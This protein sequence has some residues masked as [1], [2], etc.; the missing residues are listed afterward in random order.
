M[1]RPTRLNVEYIRKIDQPGCYGDGRGGF[2]LSLLVQVS[3][4]GLIKSWT[5]RIVRRNG[6]PTTI[7][8]GGYPS[9]GLM[10]AREQAARNILEQKSG[11]DILAGRGRSA[12]SSV[13]GMLTFEQ[14]AER[15]IQTYASSWKSAKTSE[16]WHSALSTYV[17]PRIGSIPINEVTS[18]DVY[19]V[20]S[21][22]YGSK[23]SMASKLR[24]A[25]NAI[26]AWA[27]AH[28]LVTHNPTLALRGAIKVKAQT[29][30]RRSIPWQ[31][32]PD[33]LEKVD[34]SGAMEATKLCLR[35]LALTAVRSGE[36]RGARWD[37][38][39]LEAR[40]WTIP[41]ERMKEGKEHRVPLSERVLAVLE[42]A[43][44]CSGD[45]ELVFPSARTG[46][47]LG[48]GTL[49]KLFSELGIPAVPHGLR[50]SFR[51]WAAEHDVPREVA[52]H[53]LAHVEG[54]AS[55]LAYDRS[56]YFRQR[57]GVMERWAEAIG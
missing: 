1:R 5:Q 50:S 33:A 55:S 49:S 21:P 44:G 52:E 11:V 14:A 40:V 54:S 31:E 16:V 37:E 6:R 29:T 8:L 57:V 22:V 47:V 34:A 13:A 25:I 42:R 38:V 36:A 12:S 17:Y 45:S 9:V 15:A 48:D 28:D 30:H 3:G 7:G 51:V 10:E 39:D 46:G 43:R 32:L 27:A 26:F 4:R 20:L 23:Q 41:G 19:G 56:D 2:G 35:F 53:C 18:G 24:T